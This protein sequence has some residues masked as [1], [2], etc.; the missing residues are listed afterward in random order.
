M[1]I[2]IFRIKVK[3]LKQILMVLHSELKLLLIRRK[4]RFF[5]DGLS[6][7]GGDRKKEVAQK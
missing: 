2:N 1:I 5:F 6:D 3:D 4:R 7:E